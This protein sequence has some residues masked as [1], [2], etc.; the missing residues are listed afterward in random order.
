MNNQMGVYEI[1]NVVNG[2]K[3]IGSSINIEK[4][5][6]EHFNELRKGTHYSKHLQRAVN[7]YGLDNFKFNVLE[8]AP[9]DTLREREKHYITVFETLQRDKGYNISESCTNFSAS[10]K[11]HPLFGKNFAELGY[12]NY[13]KGKKFPE[14]MK[15]KLR[16][17][18]SEQAKK[19]MSLNHA[20]V[21]GAN[22]PMYGRKYTDE[23]KTK[24]SIALK[25][26]MAGEKH[27]CYGMIRSGEL[28]GNKRKVN[29]L[30][31]DGEFLREFVTIADAGK[32]T[33]VLRQSI[34]KCCKKQ[35]ETAGGYKWEYGD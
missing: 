4:R 15:A 11:N 34:N 25:G 18:K 26:K 12:T 32:A 27:P 30:S 31:L 5:R 3:Y 24:M 19:N 28:A 8:L 7:I 35:R 33:G 1:I 14:E 23:E 17:P 9:K 10:G 2:K 6:R 13:W 29:Q 20:N 22:N 21:S 16:K